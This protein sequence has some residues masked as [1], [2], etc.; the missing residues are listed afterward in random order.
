MCVRHI[1]GEENVA[2][3][4]LSRWGNRFHTSLETEEDIALIQVSVSDIVEDMFAKQ[5]ISFR[6]FGIIANGL[7]SPKKKSLSINVEHS[8]T[9][10]LQLQ[11]LDED[12]LGF[13]FHL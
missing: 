2:A 4:I 7:T 3:D 12:K 6:N 8:Q 9:T 1:K 13:L 11:S 5:E 10:P